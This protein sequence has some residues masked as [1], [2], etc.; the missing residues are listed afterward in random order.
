LGI[1][2]VPVDCLCEKPGKMGAA[3]RSFRVTNRDHIREK[4]ASP[5]KFKYTLGFVPGDVD[6]HFSHDFHGQRVKL[7]CFQ[8]STVGFKL[9]SGQVIEEGL[10]H[11][12]PGAVVDANEKDPDFFHQI[13]P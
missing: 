8:A 4:F 1:I 12:A 3:L 2:N 11:L 7:P 9:M 5:V 10:G 13:S 6:P